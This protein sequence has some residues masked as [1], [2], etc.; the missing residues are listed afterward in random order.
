[1]NISE[2]AEFIFLKNKDRQNIQFD[3]D[4]LDTSKDLFLFFI[5]LTTKGLILLYG[6][7]NSVDLNDLTIDKF[8][9]I[10]QLLNLVGIGINLNIENNINNIP[11]KLNS[12]D[13]ENYIE[14]D[15]LNNYIFKIYA[16]NYIY[17]ITFNIK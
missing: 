14:N 15:K 1:M 2:F 16:N 4:G 7:E 17:N 9:N 3:V 8:N 12:E 5:D 6:N 13:I 11:N 10:K